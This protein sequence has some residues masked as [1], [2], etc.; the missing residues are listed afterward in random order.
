MNIPIVI[1]VILLIFLITRM[2]L[3]I[4]HKVACRAGHCQFHG[5]G[6]HDP[7]GYGPESRT[8][9]TKMEKLDEK[10]QISESN[11]QI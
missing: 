1:I 8:T 9:T 5:G 7:P 11:Q 2:P 4:M 6:G 3:I 10:F